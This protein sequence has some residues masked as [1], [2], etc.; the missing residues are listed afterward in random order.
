MR[1]SLTNKELTITTRPNSM[2]VFF[3]G[4]YSKSTGSHFG[5]HFFPERSPVVKRWGI[6]RGIHDGGPLD[7]LGLGPLLLLVWGW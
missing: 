2:G 6:E 5:I 7:T 3:L 4:F 1:V